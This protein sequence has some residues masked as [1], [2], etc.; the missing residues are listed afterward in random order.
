MAFTTNSI[1][2]TTLIDM[3]SAISACHE[4]QMRAITTICI[5]A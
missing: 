1:Q 3:S 4:G 5:G 2:N